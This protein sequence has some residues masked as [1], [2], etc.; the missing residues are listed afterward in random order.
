ME[1]FMKNALIIALALST[2]TAFA[3]TKVSKEARKEA[4]TACKAEGKT[5]K[6]LKSCVKAKL[7]APIASTEAAPVK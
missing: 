1:I 2:I 3:G 7:A 5:K 6:D 4:V